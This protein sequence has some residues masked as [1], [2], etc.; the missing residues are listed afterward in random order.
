MEKATNASA[1]SSSVRAN[2]PP[3]SIKDAPLQRQDSV[4][5]NRN[6]GPIS[7]S[8]EKRVTIRSA[9]LNRDSLPSSYLH[10]DPILDSEHAGR[11]KP[12][13][14]FQC[15]KLVLLSSKINI[16][17]VF[18]PLGIVAHAVHWSD[19]TVFILNFIAIVPL[20]K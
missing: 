13:N 14:I 6:E 20:A 10:G 9:R 12:L 1:D 11:P 8:P 3:P 19:V 2:S 4:K 17:L 16:L 5:S 7:T 15:L 18:I